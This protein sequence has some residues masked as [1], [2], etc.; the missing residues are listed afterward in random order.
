[1]DWKHA[2]LRGTRCTFSQQLAAEE[3]QTRRVVLE[4][5]VVELAE[6]PRLIKN[7]WDMLERKGEGTSIHRQL[8][9]SLPG[10]Q[11]MAQMGH[12]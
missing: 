1:M 12:K 5:L 10:E 7:S 9:S 3:I 2:G 6:A 8:A 4:M 11:N